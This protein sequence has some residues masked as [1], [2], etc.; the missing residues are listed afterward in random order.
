MNNRNP[1]KNRS[2]NRKNRNNYV[3]QL[4]NRRTRNGNTGL[5]QFGLQPTRKVMPMSI[6]STDTNYSILITS[7]GDIGYLPMPTQGLAVNERLADSIHMDDIMFNYNIILGTALTDSCRVIVFQTEGLQ[8]TGLP[9]AVTDVLEFPSNNSPFQ[10]NSVMS[11]KI[12]YD[13]THTMAVNS[14]TAIIAEKL[15]IRPAIK[16]IDF[17]PGTVQAYSG[18]VWYLLIGTNPALTNT[19]S[20]VSRLNFFSV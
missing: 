16:R 15:V 9:P 3:S 8:P 4:S 5:E 6:R 18:Q 11:F 13:R 2:N 20:F 1:R 19:F 7:A 17:V 14:P 10:T 12:L